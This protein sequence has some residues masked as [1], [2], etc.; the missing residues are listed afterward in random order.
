MDSKWSSCPNFDARFTHPYSPKIAIHIVVTVFE[1]DRFPAISPLRH[2]V[3][4]MWNHDASQQ[5]GS[6]S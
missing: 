6:H 3:G 5:S 4:K 2:V 1:K